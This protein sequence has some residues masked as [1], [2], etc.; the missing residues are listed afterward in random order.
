MRFPRF[1]ILRAETFVS[2]VLGAL[3]VLAGFCSICL[4]SPPCQALD[5]AAWHK[6]TKEGGRAYENGNFGE[7][8]RLFKA[9]IEDLKGA[10]Q[11]D[12]RL[13]ES[14][15][16][17][18]VLYVNRNQLAKAE[19]LFEKA[20]KIKEAA[21]GGSDKDVIALTSKLCVFYFNNGKRAQAQPLIDK[22]VNYGERETRQLIEINSAFSKLANYY[23]N[24]KQ[25]LENAEI[26]IKQAESETMS[27]AK[28]QAQET[29]VMLDSVGDAIKSQGDLVRQAERLYKSSLALRERSLPPQHA[30]L[31]ASLE[32]L[33]RVYQAQ[34]RTA[35]AEPL[36]RKAYEISL[37]TLGMERRETQKRMEAL[38]QLFTQQGRLSE[39]RSLYTA[40]LENK[41]KFKPSA[42]FLAG[43]AA[44]LVKEGRYSESLT[45]YARAVKMQEALNG[46]QHASLA[47]L[48]DAYAYALAKANKQSEANKIS[49]RAKA[50]RS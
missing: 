21:L 15:N 24:H 4:L 19:P 8:E 6:N 45:Y 18:A 34:G 25:K 41:E 38:A 2:G 50:I 29:A 42:D 32:N 46:P 3:V 37:T 36:L 28:S 5:S 40:A 23:S 27:E 11:N 1:S 10:P 43:Y 12:I 33:G 16:N 47:A 35:M 31:S 49:L 26:A 14:Y 13:A 44:L 22:M 30:A 17:L 9:A 7:A 48:L 20:L 39:A